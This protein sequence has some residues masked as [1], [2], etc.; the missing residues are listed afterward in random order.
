MRRQG[1]ED[2]IDFYK[3]VKRILKASGADEETK[4]KSVMRMILKR[5]PASVR[6]LNRQAAGKTETPVVER[7]GV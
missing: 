5:I 3:R 2:Y 6:Y 4:R 7:G 1:G